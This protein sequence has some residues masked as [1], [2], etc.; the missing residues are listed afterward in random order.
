MT[1]VP[2]TIDL[3]VSHHR[4]ARTRSRSITNIPDTHHVPC[5]LNEFKPG[6]R[7]NRKKLFKGSEGCGE[8]ECRTQRREAI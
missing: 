5:H 6:L 1:P 8:L 4:K 3:F 2:L 7:T